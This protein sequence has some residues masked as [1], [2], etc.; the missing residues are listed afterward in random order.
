MPTTYDRLPATLAID[1]DDIT[2]FF[3]EADDATVSEI[4]A[5]TA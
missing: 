5:G 1:A 4:L 3:A 2:A